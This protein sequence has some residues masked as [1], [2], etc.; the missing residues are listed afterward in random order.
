[1]GSNIPIIFAILVRAQF[2]PRRVF[3]RRRWSSCPARPL[4]HHLCSTAQH[5]ASESTQPRRLWH[6]IPHGYSDRGPAS[7]L[8]LGYDGSFFANDLSRVGIRH[9]QSQRGDGRHDGHAR[10]HARDEGGAGVVITC[11]HA[12]G[13]VHH[14]SAASAAVVLVLCSTHSRSIRAICDTRTEGTVSTL[15]TKYY[16]VKRKQGYLQNT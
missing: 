12:R 10:R 13:A 8:Q 6:H 7:S 1:M 2:A 11:A 5:K 4:R 15:L 16:G 3:P 9:R 14:L